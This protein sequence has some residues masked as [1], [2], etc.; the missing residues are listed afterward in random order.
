MKARLLTG[1]NLAERSGDQL[2]MGAEDIEQLTRLARRIKRAVVVVAIEMGLLGVLTALCVM[3]FYT[4]VIRHRKGKRTWLMLSAIFC[5]GAFTALEAS[6]DVT[7]LF[8]RIRANLIDRPDLSFAER[9]A[10]YASL[11]WWKAERYLEMILLPASDAGLVFLLNDVLASWRALVFWKSVPGSNR[12]LPLLLYFVLFSNFAFSV[13]ITVTMCIYI[14]VSVSNNSDPLAIV[15][16]TQSALSIATNL[17]ATG[18][19]GYRA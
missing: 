15:M 1:L 11:S 19:T 3:A 5:A 12:S 17:I 16:I 6:L 10:A 4:I 13:A 2:T 9:M 18:M 14:D 8:L 7:S